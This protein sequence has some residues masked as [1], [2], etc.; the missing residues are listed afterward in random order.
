MSNSNTESLHITD[1]MDRLYN[2]KSKLHDLAG[3]TMGWRN[4]EDAENYLSKIHTNNA[5]TIKATNKPAFER[6]DSIVNTNSCYCVD[7]VCFAYYTAGSQYIPANN[8]FITKFTKDTS[9]R[10][11]TGSECERAGAANDTDS[12]FH[13]ANAHDAL[14][15][16]AYTAHITNGGQSATNLGNLDKVKSSFKNFRLYYKV[17]TPK[18]QIQAEVSKELYLKG[19][20]VNTFFQEIHTQSVTHDLANSSFSCMNVFGGNLPY[21]MIMTVA[22][23]LSSYIF[24]MGRYERNYS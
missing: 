11:F 1:V 24:Y 6:I 23:F 3:C 9:R 17:L 2:S 7:D 12:D 21:V 13:I 19:S 10:I 16:A 18:V 8:R 22:I 20:S 5:N 15:H 4:T 14:P